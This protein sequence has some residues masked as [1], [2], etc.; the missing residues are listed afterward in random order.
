MCLNLV[1]K[2]GKLYVFYHKMSLYNFNKVCSFPSN[3]SLVVNS[4]GDY[5]IKLKENSFL[6]LLVKTSVCKLFVYKGFLYIE[7]FTL[8]KPAFNKLKTLLSNSIKGS[9]VNY[10]ERISIHGVGYRFID[11]GFPLK[12]AIKAGYSH[13]VNLD[14]PKNISILFLSNTELFLYSSSHDSLKLFLLQ[15]KKVRFPDPY[16]SKGIR[17][18]NEVLVTKSGATK[19]AL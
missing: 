9:V 6:N 19:K 16:K 7:N 5:S 4:Q 13:L 2:V 15:I 3:L 11:K 18:F 1:L 17:Y 12:F 14:I 8:Q 10:S